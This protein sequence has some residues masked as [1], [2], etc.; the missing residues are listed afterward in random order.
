M[1]E[2]DS[3]IE[4]L[5]QDIMDS[6]LTNPE[7]DILADDLEYANAIN[8]SKDPV[9]IGIKRLTLSGIR[10]KLSLHASIRREI[11][12]HA[13][14]CNRKVTTSTVTTEKRT[15]SLKEELMCALI[16]NTKTAIITIGVAATI[17]ALAIVWTRQISE[18]GGF[19]R[20]AAH[21]A[22]N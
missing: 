20:D 17:V 13:N 8:G 19:V 2:H 18:A 15:G 21:A 10:T 6:A 22:N 9:M 11:A 5:A 14:G 7:K 4:M 1:S 16:A 3:R 12:E